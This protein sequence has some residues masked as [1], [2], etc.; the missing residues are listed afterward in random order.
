[1]FFYA[2]YEN[3]VPKIRSNPSTKGKG[4]IYDPRINNL[5]PSIKYSNEEKN[6]INNIS[7]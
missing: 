3:K 7:N 6:N 5:L 2:D 1:M 4:A